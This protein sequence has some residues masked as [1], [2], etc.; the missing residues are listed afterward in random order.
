MRGSRP[1]NAEEGVLT[2]DAYLD[3]DIIEL[4]KL[5]GLGLHD[6]WV[7]C[8]EGVPFRQLWLA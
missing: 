6:D 2:F 1:S 5:E 3:V 4:N 8:P 7:A